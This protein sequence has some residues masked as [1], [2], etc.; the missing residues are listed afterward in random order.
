MPYVWYMGALY[1]VFIF[2][3]MFLL[4]AAWHTETSVMLTAL[5]TTSYL[6]G[7]MQFSLEAGLSRCRRR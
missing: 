3:H 2:T 4:R 7:G 5:G 6:C 1:M